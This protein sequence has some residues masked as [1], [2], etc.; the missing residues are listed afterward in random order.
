MKKNK[1]FFF[2]IILT[3]VVLLNNCSKGPTVTDI[4][5]GIYDSNAKY[6]NTKSKSIKILTG[7]TIGSLSKRYKITKKELIKFNKLKSPYILKPG[8]FI[9]IPIP[10]NT[11]L[12]KVILYIK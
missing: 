1:F 7:D 6:S 9:K 5:K 12:R 11:K 3:Y 4:V 10:K 8:K 2:Y